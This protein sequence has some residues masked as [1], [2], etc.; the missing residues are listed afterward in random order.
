MKIL[1]DIILAFIILAVI[2]LL[3]FK[4]IV[5]LVLTIIVFVVGGV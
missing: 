4:Y 5:T 1:R 2:S 3:A